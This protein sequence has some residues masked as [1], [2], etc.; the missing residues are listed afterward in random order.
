MANTGCYLYGL[1]RASEDRE[2]GDIGLEHEG[3]P[4]RVS[5]L[6]E[7]SIAAVV[8]PYA[9]RGKILP[10]RKNLEPHN[11]VIRELM[12]TVT[13]VPMTFGH[14]AKSE[15]E[16][17]K[18]LRRNRA[19]IQAQ[20]ERVDGKVEMGLKIV[21]G[22][23][24]IFEHFVS[25]DPELKARRDEIFGRSSNPSQSE[26]IELGRMFEQRLAQ[27]REEQTEAVLELLQPSAAEVKVNPARSEK[28]VMD[29]AFLVTRTGIKQLEERVYQVAE[30]FP[31]EYV[32]D[33]SGPWAPFNFIEL[34]LQQV[35]A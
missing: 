19:D 11:R 12:R 21:W 13:I 26:K 14:V 30:S 27:E 8:T 23:D 24:N 22:V 35:A 10:L 34:D 20:L 7:G 17:R 25:I 31:A 3:K 15:E 2:F 33:V 16:I 18:M 29:L 6:R 4:G 9:G 32:F 1:I 5:T 28:M